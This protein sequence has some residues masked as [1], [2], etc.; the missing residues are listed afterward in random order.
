MVM[1][2]VEVEEIT[3]FVTVVMEDITEVLAVM[4]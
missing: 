2:V 1:V 3:E 4:V